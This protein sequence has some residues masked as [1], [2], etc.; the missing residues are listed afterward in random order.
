MGE[1]SSPRDLRSVMRWFICLELTYFLLFWLGNVNKCVKGLWPWSK[2]V[3]TEV[4]V[5]RHN[6]HTLAF[7][8]DTR[9]FT[10]ANFVEYFKLILALSLMNPLHS[11]MYGLVKTNNLSAFHSV[12]QTC[13]TELVLMYYYCTVRYCNFYLIKRKCEC[14]I[15]L[16]AQWRGVEFKSPP[17]WSTAAH[18]DI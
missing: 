1:R 4:P 10:I 8:V 11:I 12:T 7:M 17:N 18:L 16:M 6:R 2:G 5:P 9:A 15:Y 13:Q 14:I 3:F